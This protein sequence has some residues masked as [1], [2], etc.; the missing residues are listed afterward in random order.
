LNKKDFAQK[1]I[2]PLTLKKAVITWLKNK[3]TFWTSEKYEEH[4]N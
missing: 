1:K 4:R 2:F 3:K